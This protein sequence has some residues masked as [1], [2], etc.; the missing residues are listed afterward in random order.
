MNERVLMVDDEENILQAYGRV[1]RRKFDLVTALG[2][3]AGV[4]RLREEGPFAVLVT[5]MRM[6]VV[7]GL[8]MLEV[9][10]E[11]CPDTVRIMLTGNADQQTAIDAVNE[12]AIF[13]FLNKPCEADRL[14]RTLE[15]ALHQYRLVTAEK[16]LLEN[17]LRGALDMLVE[18]AGMV[19]ADT[20]GRA[21]AMAELSEAVARQMGAPMPWTFAMAGLLSQIGALTLPH[22]LLGKIR[23]G[24]F[25]N[26]EERELAARLPEIG[27]SLLRHLPRLEEVAEAV[28]YMQKNINGT[29]FPVDDRRGGG[30]PLGGRILRVVADFLALSQGKAPLTTVHDMAFRTTWYDEEV[31]RALEAVLELRAESAPKVPLRIGVRQARL[32][33]VLVSDVETPEGLLVIPGGTRLGLSHLERLRNFARMGNLREP[34]DAWET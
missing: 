13:R 22:D 11:V 29:G 17:T 14:S 23:K 30:I 33:M 7:D 18:V 6:P 21:R 8:K 20:F 9:A 10:R 19:D 4:A 15:A 26:S 5:D 25:L 32:G 2:G 3:E 24:S 34:F 31:L 27:A 16:D 28:Y 12:G 1:L